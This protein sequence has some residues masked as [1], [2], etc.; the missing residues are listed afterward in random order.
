MR[1]SSS[2][3]WMIASISALRFSAIRVGVPGIGLA[4]LAG[5]G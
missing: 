1:V 4:V 2:L 3:S 5:A